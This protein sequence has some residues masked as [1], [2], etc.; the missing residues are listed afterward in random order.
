M[1]KLDFCTD[2]HKWIAANEGQMRQG[3]DRQVEIVCSEC[4]ALERNEALLLN[5]DDILLGRD[6]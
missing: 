4:L 5:T 1:G 6:E 3:P 2:C